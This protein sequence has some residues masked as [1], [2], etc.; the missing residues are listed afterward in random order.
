MGVPNRG[1]RSFGL[2]YRSSRNSFWFRNRKFGSYNRFW[3]WTHPIVDERPTDDKPAEALL[4]Y[5]MRPPGHGVV[6][7]ATSL[8][9]KLRQWLAVT[10]GPRV[11]TRLTRGPP[12]SCVTALGS[13]G[14]VCRIDHAAAA[15]RPVTGD[16]PFIAARIRWTPLDY[17]QRR[18]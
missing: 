10:H 6:T 14:C 7:P 9:P 15:L 5:G 17:R 11:A 4:P 13:N 1:T 12:A 8:L 16:C 18:Y 2:R 3:N